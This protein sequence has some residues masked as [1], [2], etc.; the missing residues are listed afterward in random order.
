MCVIIYS[1]QKGVPAEWTD[2][3]LSTCWENHPDG[4]G[5]MWFSQGKRFVKKGFMD[6]KDLLEAVGK[7]RSDSSLVEHLTIHFRTGTGGKGPENTHPF[8]HAPSKLSVMH[9]GVVGK[10]DTVGNR[11]DTK[12]MVDLAAS[13]NQLVKVLEYHAK[14]YNKFITISDAGAVTFYGEWLKTPWGYASNGSY[15]SYK[16]WYKSGTGIAQFDLDDTDG[17]VIELMDGTE[18]TVA[19]ICHGLG[20][21]L[22]DTFISAGLLYVYTERGSLITI[23]VGIVVEDEKCL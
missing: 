16:G 5:M 15:E 23:P 12:V 18:T 13:K 9:N 4:A 21:R 22:S 11:S 10:C 7:L 19:D 1:N 2:E 17:V 6:E 20:I 3:L 14:M 8:L